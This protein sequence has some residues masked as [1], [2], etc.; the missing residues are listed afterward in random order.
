MI[1]PWIYAAGAVAIGLLSG[2]V[3]AALVRRIILDGRRD[4]QEAHDAARATGTFLF[5][6]FDRVS[7]HFF[8]L[9]SGHSNIV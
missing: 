7:F 3:G 9:T 6:F 1:D 5:L 2:V 8:A 4:R